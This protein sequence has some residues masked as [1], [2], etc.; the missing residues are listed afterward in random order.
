M[1]I[2]VIVTT[3]NNPRALRAVLL[4]YARQDDTGF[5]VIV[6]DDGSGPATR[7][8]VDS[9]RSLLPYELT[10]VWQEDRGFRAAAIRNRAIA[11]SKSE[12]LI[13]TDGDCIPSSRFVRVHRLLAEPG[14]FLSGNR[15]LLNE[16]LA[17]AVLDQELDLSGWSWMQGVQCWLRRDINRMMP[18]VLL[19]D[20]Q[21]R[22][23]APRRWAG[24]V[25]ANLSAWRQDLLKVNGFDESYCG[26][27]LEDSDLV[28]RLMHAGI[29]HKSARFGAFIWHLWH[30]YNDRE[31]LSDNEA[32]FDSLLDSDRIGCPS[33]VNQY[34]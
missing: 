31:R 17:R 34:L 18:L 20:G 27:G 29:F 32:R 4:G 23:M 22:K 8:L 15:I 9:L 10:H 2:S 30:P 28:V 14:W 16:D 24:C 5:D 12:Y 7:E 21:W 6:A 3:Y 33:G 26:W 19:P 1:R 13:F 25:T 11:A